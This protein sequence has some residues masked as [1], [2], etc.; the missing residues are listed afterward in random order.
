MMKIEYQKKEKMES[1][2]RRWKV[3]ADAFAKQ[4]TEMLKNDEKKS[5]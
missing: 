5:Y 1:R 4:R 3:Y 2:E